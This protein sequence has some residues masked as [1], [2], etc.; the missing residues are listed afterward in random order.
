MSRNDV[1]VG[2]ESDSVMFATRRAAGPVIGEAPGAGSTELGAG[3]SVE[4][5]AV[6]TSERV[7]GMIGSSA[8]LPLSNRSR[9]SSET[10]AGSRRYCSYITCTN[11]ALWVPKTN[12]LTP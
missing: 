1:A 11:A 8:D 6:T 4:G 12:S 2:T 5:V 7:T 9:H 10:E 3:R